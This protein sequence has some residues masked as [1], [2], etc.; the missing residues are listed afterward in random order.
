MI[1]LDQ[2]VSRYEASIG[3]CLTCEACAISYSTYSEEVDIEVLAMSPSALATWDKIKFP[4]MHKTQEGY[5][6]KE[7]RLGA[8][9]YS[10][11]ILRGCIGSSSVPHESISAPTSY[12]NITPYRYQ[13]NY[14]IVHDTLA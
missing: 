4:T 11:C 6:S 5:M 14:G 13:D 1:P 3:P 10:T 2:V 7:T 9:Q 8:P 12:Y